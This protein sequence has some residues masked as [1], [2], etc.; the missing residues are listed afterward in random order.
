MDA[1]GPELADI[2]KQSPVYERYARVAPRR[3]DWTSHIART[4]E[5]VQADFDWAAE[6]A[7]LTAPPML[8]YADADSI[9]PDHIVELYGLPGG[10]HARRRRRIGRPT[11][12]LAVLPGA[13]HYDIVASPLLPA[14]V[15]PFLDAPGLES[16]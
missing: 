2:I 1:M 16:Q 3:E 13:T 9:R 6:V 8:V 11:A 4:A 10:G 12:R 14:A 5:F 7:R 15:V